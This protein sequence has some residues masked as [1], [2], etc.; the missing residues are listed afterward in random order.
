M[1]RGIQKSK[2]RDM[3]KL[4][5]I[6][7]SILL[8]LF[9]NTCGSEQDSFRVINTSLKSEIDDFLSEAKKSQ[10]YIG[11][12]IVLSIFPDSL[13]YRIILI[14]EIP[15]DCQYFV[16]SKSAGSGNM[17][18]FMDSTI[19]DDNPLVKVADK[20]KC[21]IKEEFGMPS[22]YFSKEYLFEENKLTFVN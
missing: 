3:L 11:E 16:G 14:N 12:N 4:N 9:L 13:N 5:Q 6:F 22:N 19:I 17:Y 7:A 15:K 1:I 8:C 21:E 18:L 10:L 20:E 2:N